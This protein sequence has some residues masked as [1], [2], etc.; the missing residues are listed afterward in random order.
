[1]Q[2]GEDKAGVHNAIHRPRILPERRRELLR[3]LGLDQGLSKNGAQRKCVRRFMDEPFGHYQCIGMFRSIKEHGAPKI[4]GG[5][6][7]E[8]WRIITA[9]R[10]ND[11]TYKVGDFL[12]K[13]LVRFADQSEGFGQRGLSLS[14]LR[15][16]KWHEAN[17]HK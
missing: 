14:E 15:G 6:S 7:T 8:T 16:C 4:K 11:L 10:K 5:R 17:G 9:P 12:S 3:Q 2:A 13:L 1:M